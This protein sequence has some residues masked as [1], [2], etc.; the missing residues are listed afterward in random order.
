MKKHNM[1][2]AMKAEMEKTEKKSV[3][4]AERACQLHAETQRLR[5]AA[6]KLAEEYTLVQEKLGDVDAHLRKIVEEMKD[7]DSLKAHEIENRKRVY[8]AEGAYGDMLKDIQHYVAL[9]RHIGPL[10]DLTDDQRGW[11]AA[12]GLVEISL[13]QLARKGV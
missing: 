1:L 11:N 8:M 10:E 4:W 7:Y 13:D 5:G 9:A 3:S 2:S 6:I 12:L